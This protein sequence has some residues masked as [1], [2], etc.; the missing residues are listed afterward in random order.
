MLATY[1]KF[2]S[3]FQFINNSDFSDFSQKCNFSVNY[4]RSWLKKIKCMGGNHIQHTCISNGFYDVTFRSPSKMEILIEEA[5]N[6]I[7]H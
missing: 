1:L 5:E 6:A 7:S 2:V 3:I 4:S